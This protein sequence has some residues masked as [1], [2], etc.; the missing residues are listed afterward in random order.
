MDIVGLDLHKRE[1]QLAL[2][3]PDG[4]IT[5][6]RIATS[7]ERFTG[8]LGDRPRARI[9]PEESTESEWVARHLESLGHEVIV[10]D[11][12]Y[13]P[14]CANRSRR[15][16]TDKR[17]ARTLM[18]ACAI[19]AYRPAHRL[20]DGRRHV[21]AE[22]AVRDALV[23]TRVRYAG[24]AKTFVR[25]EGAERK[26]LGRAGHRPSGPS[27]RRQPNREAWDERPL[28]PE[29]H[30][31]Q[32]KSKLR[33]RSDSQ[34]IGY[35]NEAMYSTCLFCLSALGANDVI[36][37]FPVGRRLAFDAAK[38]R[39]W[40]V[41]RTCE[42]WN[43]TPVEERWEAIEE[44]ERV[45]RG[46]TRRVSTDNVGLARVGEGLE[47][48]R[49]GEPQ[50]PEMAAWR[51]G[52][53]FGRRQR[54]FIVWGGATIVG[55]AG[56]YAGPVLVGP[57]LGL[58]AVEAAALLAGLVSFG[59]GMVRLRA[60]RVKM[61]MPG[62]SKPVIISYDNLKA[63]RLLSADNE[64]GWALS[65]PILPPGPWE[66]G[67]PWSE[68]TVRWMRRLYQTTETTFEGDE[69]VRIA[70]HVL[71]KLNASGAGKSAVQ[72]AVRLLED[73]AK[74]TDI[75][76]KS[77]VNGAGRMS[78]RTPGVSLHHVPK[79]IRL[80]LEMAAHE[81]TERRALEGELAM[82]EAAWRDAEEIAAISDSMFLPAGVEAWIKK[83]KPEA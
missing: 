54:R 46:T 44:C 49:I 67:D 50:R 70:G 48:V 16:K 29:R 24:L 14:M 8:A 41:C 51:Y 45:F 59:S 62:S 64:S 42:R 68:V 47:L 37:H 6:R 69:A 15:T 72:D 80:A 17:D 31:R 12:N 11:P 7:R 82:L 32:D 81:D 57:A 38:G 58:Y 33:D 53:Q 34:P 27:R 65:V 77:V 56:V 74:P 75:F 20:A 5:D 60:T 1:S 30:H 28:I 3:G 18:E 66:Q 76:A 9:L 21:R 35:R 61:A 10:A 25:R 43:L 4:T 71:P 52:D 73:Q 13:A 63:V 79:P 55:V 26:D 36:E 83:Q 23:R 19:G 78:K 2:K 22:L 40:V 39:L